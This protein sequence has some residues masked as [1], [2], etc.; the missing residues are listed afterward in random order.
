MFHLSD[1]FFQIIGYKT[2]TQIKEETAK[3]KEK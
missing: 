3:N 2:Q 1:E